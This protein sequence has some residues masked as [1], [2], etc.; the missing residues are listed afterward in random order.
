MEIGILLAAL[1]L[2][3]VIVAVVVVA[4]KIS[5]VSAVIAQE[6]DDELRHIRYRSGFCFSISTAFAAGYGKVR[7]C[8]SVRESR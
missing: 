6:E 8:Q 2:F 1:I 3:V 5:S 4:A 7:M